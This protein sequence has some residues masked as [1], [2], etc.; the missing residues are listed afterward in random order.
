MGIVILFWSYASLPENQDICHLKVSIATGSDHLDYP[1]HLGDFLSRSKW[2][3]SG[4]A[5]M[6]DPDV[7]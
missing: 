2:V 5:H 7:H 4:H 1:D 3:S 6:P